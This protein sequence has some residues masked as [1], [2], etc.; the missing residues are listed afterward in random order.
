MDFKIYENILDDACIKYILDNI[1]E[2]RYMDGRV[3]AGQRVNKSHKNRK[4]LF[5]HENNILSKI[6]TVIY[7]NLY[8]DIKRNFSDIKYRERWKLGK[9]TGEEKGFYKTHRDDSDETAFRNTSMICALSDPSEYEGGELCFDLL[10]ENLKLKKGSVVVFKSSVFHHVNPVTS[11]LRIVLISFFFDETGKKIKEQLNPTAPIINY[12][13]ILNNVVN[14]EYDDNNV[15][16]NKVKN[17]VSKVNGDI[18]YS[19]NKKNPWTDN[20]DLWFEDNN[21]DVLLVSFAGMGWKDSIPTF[22]F[23]NFLKQYNVDKLF[24]R[25]IT[26]RYYIT[27]LKNSTKSLEE[28][29]ELLREK[30]NIKPYKKIIALGCSAGAFAAILYGEILNFTKIIAFAPQTVINHKKELL[31]EDIYNAPNTCKWLTTRYLENEYYNKCLDLANFKPFK[32]PIDIHYSINGNKGI[33]KKHA[34]YLESNNCFIYEHPGNDHM[35]ALTLR[36]KGKLQKI[37]EKEIMQK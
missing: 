19:D 4:D 24:V 32:T 26:C 35:I 36:N 1:D 3:G 25:D 13:P 11:G 37:I 14:I 33:D 30:I 16:N 23:Y 12:K 18:D 15:D 17:T 20:D 34:L 5:I 28:T 27:G 29:I 6:D 8:E 2:K 31:I 22:I 10:N 7:S 21:S 9:Y